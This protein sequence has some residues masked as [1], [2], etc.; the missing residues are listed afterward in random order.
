MALDLNNLTPV[1]GNSRRGKAPQV[2]AYATA[3]TNATVDGSGYFNAGSAYKGAYN[4]LEIGDIIFV[5]VHTTSV[6]SGT[7]ADAGV[8]IVNGKASGV[9]DVTNAVDLLVTDAD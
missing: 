8:H 1:G 7:I 5:V 3:D 6:G 4:M 2:F 9:L